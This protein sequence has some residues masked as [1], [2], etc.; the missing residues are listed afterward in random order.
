MKKIF[1]IYKTFRGEEF[2][3][4]SLMSIY[5]YVSGVLF[6]HQ[7]IG[8][9]GRTGNTVRSVVEKAYDPENKVFHLNLEGKHTQDEQYNAAI[10]WLNSPS[11]TGYKCDFDYLQLID[12][13]EVWDDENYQRV[14]EAINSGREEN[15]R[16]RMYDYIKSPFYQIEPVSP[17]R[18]MC[19]VHR[20]F[21]K[22][23]ALNIRGVL[24]PGTNLDNVLFHH[25]CSVRKNVEEV[26]AKHA[27]SCGIE[28]EPIED[29]QEWIERVWNKLPDAINLLPLKNHN[30]Q[31]RSVKAVSVDSLPPVL[32]SNALVL[33]AAPVVVTRSQ[34][35]INRTI[36]LALNMI[37]GPNDYDKLQGVLKKVS[38]AFDE[39]I[40]VDT[41][42]DERLTKA[43]ARRF[44]WK[45][46]RYPLGNFGG[47][48]NLALE[49]TKSDY[50]MWLDCDDIPPNAEELLKIKQAVNATRRDFYF[51]RYVIDNGKTSFKRE[52]IF[53]N[54]PCAGWMHPVHELV[55]LS[56][57]KTY[58]DINDSFIGHAPDKHPLDGTK[59]NIAILENELSRGNPTAHVRFH[60]AKDLLLKIRQEPNALEEARALCMFEELIKNHELKGTGH[61]A[62]V[63][64]TLAMWYGY[65]RDGAFK[66]ENRHKIEMFSRLA[67]S[68]D[69]DI[70]EPCVM[71]GDCYTTDEAVDPQTPIE[72]YKQALAKT[73]DGILIRYMPFYFE[74][75]SQRLVMMYGVIGEIELALHH[76]RRMLERSPNDPS[77]MKVRKEL[78]AR[79]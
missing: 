75:P 17:L 1:A 39:I 5:P 16:C 2:A 59:R 42:G 36:T 74:I 49:A 73:G 45:T 23:N 70:A 13:D 60:L 28:R 29:K 47:A 68:M 18:S 27:A 12:T 40:I 79:L 67:L 38:K 32:R 66:K 8:W 64:N 26:W 14:L 46:D 33:S 20:S 37:V 31:W 76:N 54:D 55:N 56:Y 6:V 51:M 9:D 69:H 34:Q 41:Y 78:V 21:V 48:R 15:Y 10:K 58:G 44:Q 53:R 65:G 61:A 24:L 11:N 50:V 30:R 43:G 57:F 35:K 7:D 63:L 71:L 4:E 3:L 25:F 22:P 19:F 52:R 77:L 72:W 62:Y